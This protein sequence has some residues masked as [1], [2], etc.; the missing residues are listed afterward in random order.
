VRA[1][2]PLAPSPAGLDGPGLGAWLGR[3]LPAL[4]VPVRHPGNHKYAWAL[5]RRGAGHLPAGQPYPKLPHP[6]GRLPA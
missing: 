5:D 3:W 4:T 1:F 2:A 6:G